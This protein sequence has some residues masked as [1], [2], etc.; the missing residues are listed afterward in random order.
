M[1]RP[2][3]YRPQ[4]QSLWT[5]ELGRRTRIAGTKPGMDPFR[6]TRPSR[7]S[8]AADVMNHDHL[9]LCPVFGAVEN[10]I[11]QDRHSSDPSLVNSFPPHY[12]TSTPG[13]PVGHR[14]S[15][16]PPSRPY[17]HG[18]HYHGSSPPCAIPDG[19][20][21]HC[22]PV[23]HRTATGTQAF[24]ILPQ[25]HA[26]SNNLHVLCSLPQ[27]LNDDLS[28]RCFFH[29]SLVSFPDLSYCL[30]AGLVGVRSL[31]GALKEH[32]SFNPFVFKL[33]DYGPCTLFRGTSNGAFTAT[34]RS[35]TSSAAAVALHSLC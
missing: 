12:L 26:S 24:A 23:I 17:R 25:S 29:Y 20:A 1:G 2:S 27:Y 6:R 16:L 30:A 19:I 33:A 14:P 10:T 22:F 28:S 11:Y 3:P 4:Q 8:C 15:L 7:H 18:H 13:G 21:R 32:C 31:W 35:P 5:T 34:Q 9:H